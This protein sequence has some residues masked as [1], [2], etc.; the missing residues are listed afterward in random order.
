MASLEAWQTWNYGDFSLGE[1]KKKGER[2]EK[3]RG[4]KPPQSSA[5]GAQ[6]GAPQAQG[7]RGGV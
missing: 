6:G 4:A 1:P 7:V 3:K 5:P 2:K